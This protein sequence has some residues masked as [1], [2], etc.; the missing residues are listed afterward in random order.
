MGLLLGAGVALSELRRAAV[1]LVLGRSL[2]HTS[3]HRDSYLLL[4]LVLML[5]HYTIVVSP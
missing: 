1:S 4:D 5:C 3:L 2:N